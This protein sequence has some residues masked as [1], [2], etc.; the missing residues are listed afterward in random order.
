MCISSPEQIV[1]DE[2]IAYKVMEKFGGGYRPIFLNA[3]NNDDRVF[4]PLNEYDVKHVAYY[5][6]DEYFHAFANL[7]IAKQYYHEFLR[8]SSGWDISFDIVKSNVVVVKVLL[9]VD[10]IRETNNGTWT[11]HGAVAGKTMLIVKEMP[12]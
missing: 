12:L 10:L 7:E 3:R 1:A 11:I 4:L 9:S 6:E 2:I 8:S 5:P